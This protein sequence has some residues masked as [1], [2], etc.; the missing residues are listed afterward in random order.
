VGIRVTL[1]TAVQIWSN[2]QRGGAK[3]RR[4]QV[5]RLRITLQA[6][7]NLQGHAATDP[8]HA[9][10]GHNTSALWQEVKQVSHPLVMIV[11]VMMMKV[12]KSPPHMNLRKPL[13]VLRIVALNKRLNLKH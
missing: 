11:I 5:S 9:H 7:M 6:K 4:L 12:R 13:N 2:P 1:G 10:H 8:H 3:A